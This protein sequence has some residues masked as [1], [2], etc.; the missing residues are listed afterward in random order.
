MAYLNL[1]TGLAAGLVLGGRLWRGAAGVAGEIGHLPIDPA[2]DVCGCGQRGCLETFASGSGVA[3]RWARGAPRGARAVRGGSPRRAD[4]LRVKGELVDGVA[5]A[6][7]ILVLTAGVEIVV[8]GG[9]IS[10]LG[11]RLRDEVAAR[12]DDWACD[13]AFLRSVALSERIRIVPDRTVIA[14][15]G[16]AL[17]GAVDEAGP[18]T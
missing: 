12:L 14:A 9:G 13:S 16:A 1:G 3:R 5:A 11:E 18:R 17:V 10:A 8:I 15:L 4:A 7:R 6:V 2:G